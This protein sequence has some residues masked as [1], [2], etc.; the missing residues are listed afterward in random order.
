L[1][2]QWVGLVLALGGGITSVISGFQR[3]WEV[4]IIGG[5]VFI[6]GMFALTHG[7]KSQD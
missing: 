7:R 2:L 5:I 3:N 4:A 6:V 1:L